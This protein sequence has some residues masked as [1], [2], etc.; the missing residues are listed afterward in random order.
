MIIIIHPLCFVSL[1]LW[2]W[3]WKDAPTATREYAPWPLS[4][5]AQKQWYCEPCHSDFQSLFFGQWA[6]ERIFIRQENIAVRGKGEY[7]SLD[8][9]LF[10]KLKDQI[11]YINEPQNFPVEPTEDVSPEN[12]QNESEKGSGEDISQII[13]EANQLSIEAGLFGQFLL[14]THE[15]KSIKQLIAEFNKNSNWIK[16]LKH[17]KTFITFLKEKI[18]RLKNKTQKERLLHSK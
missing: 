6:R 10:N 5:S 8:Q 11:L 18:D 14:Y 9:G 13:H 3:S 17:T 16:N 15:N 1:S 4:E 12:P 7:Y 2:L